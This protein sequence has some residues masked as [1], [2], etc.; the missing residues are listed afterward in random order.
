M[1]TFFIC[2]SASVAMPPC[3]RRQRWSWVESLWKGKGPEPFNYPK[4]PASVLEV[5]SDIV[6]VSRDQAYAFTHLLFYLTDFGYR[7]APGIVEVQST[8][9]WAKP[10]VCWLGTWDAEDYDLSGELLMTWPLLGAQMEPRSGIW[11]RLS[12]QSG[13]QDWAT[14]LWEHKP[15]YDLRNWVGTSRPIRPWNRLPHSVRNGVPMRHIP[16]IRS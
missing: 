6:G 11:F 9:S 12:H 5:P 13:R 14:S 7:S 8:C 2:R 1:G 4:V 15:G 16:E 3:L 10:R